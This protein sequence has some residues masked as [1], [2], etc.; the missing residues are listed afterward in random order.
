MD[1]DAGG[2][3]FLPPGHPFTLNFFASVIWSAT[4]SVPTPA[5]P[6]HAWLAQFNSGSVFPADKSTEL[7]AWCVRGGHGHDG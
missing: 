3:P 4:T 6:S 7:A 1:P 5:A 2:L